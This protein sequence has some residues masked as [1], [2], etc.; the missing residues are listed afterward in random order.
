MSTPAFAN[1]DLGLTTAW[2]K[3]GGLQGFERIYRL[4]VL[5][6]FLGTSGDAAI[7]IEVAYDFDDT[8]VAP[9]NY[10]FNYDPSVPNTPIQVQHHL[11]KQKCESVRF[12]LTCSSADGAVRLTG[13]NIVVGVKGQFFKLSSANR[14]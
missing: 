7:S 2:L 9:V 10:T 1:V 4:T 3:L 5:G 11:P 14:V 6:K 12:R 13:L 8:F